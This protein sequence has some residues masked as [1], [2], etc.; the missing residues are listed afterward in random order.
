M[1]KYKILINS[2]CAQHNAMTALEQE[3]V[4]QRSRKALL[5]FFKTKESQSD[6]DLKLK[7]EEVCLLEAAIDEIYSSSLRP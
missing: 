4:F 6:F 5:T 2:V 3:V 1:N 7:I